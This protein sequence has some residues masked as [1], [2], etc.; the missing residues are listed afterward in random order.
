MNLALIFAGISFLASA[1][2]LALLIIFHFLPTGY[3]PIS[4]P[5]SNYGVGKYAYLFRI[6]LWASVIAAIAFACALAVSGS[7]PISQWIFTLLILLAVSRLGISLFPTDIQGRPHTR[8]GVLH[9]IFAILT[10]AFVYMTIWA[11]TPILIAVAPWQSL[12]GVLTVLK[13]IVFYSLIVFIIVL[14]VP[15]LKRIVGISERLFLVSENVWFVI[16]TALL[17][18]KLF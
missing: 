9:Y 7:L 17:V 11:L 12:S 6:Y 3:N 16:G 5:V 18:A 10:F 4:Q 13:G 14:I 15:P 1:S 8:N 2:Y